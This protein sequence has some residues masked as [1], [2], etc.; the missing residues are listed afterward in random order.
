M[1]KVEIE[2]RRI[3]L[4]LGDGI[5]EEVGE[6]SYSDQPASSGMGTLGDLLKAGQHKKERS[7]KK[8]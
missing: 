1:E 6:R 4:A 5:S 2:Q 7:R 3:S 8:R